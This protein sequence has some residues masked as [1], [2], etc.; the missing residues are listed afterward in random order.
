METIS[1]LTIEHIVIA[2]N[3]PDEK[4]LEA[5][6]TRMGSI[7]D[8]K[9]MTRKLGSIDLT[10]TS[11]EQIV[12]IIETHLG[13]SGFTIFN[14]VEHTPLIA[15]SGKTSRVTQ[16][17]AGNPLFAVQMSRLLPEVALY[18][19]LRFA[20]YQD[21]SGRTFVAYDNFLSQLA[22]YQREEITRTAQVVQDSLRT[23]LLEVTQ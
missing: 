17:L 3:Q 9:E 20:V 6:K 16:Y 23:L 21:E 7:E 15:L 1:T 18:A 11:W 10:S 19:P 12:Q 5:L 2:S 13:T 22:Q 4:V 14:T 8:W